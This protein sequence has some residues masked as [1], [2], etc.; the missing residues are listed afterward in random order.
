MEGVVLVELSSGALHYTKSFSEAFDSRHPKTERLNLSAL[1]FAL[2]SFAGSSIH[3]MAKYADE[4]R[5][6]SST[7]GVADIA[8]LATPLENMVLAATP[9][10]RLL[11]VLFTTPY[12]E[13]EVA[14][15]LIRRVAYHYENPDSSDMQ[16]MTVLNQVVRLWIAKIR[17]G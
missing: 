2:Q 11:V 5:E 16:L 9:S 4:G 8:M 7:T 6:T 3:P 1:I 12:F 14:K 15:Y 13:A 10:N 17:R